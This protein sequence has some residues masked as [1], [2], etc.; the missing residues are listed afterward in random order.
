MSVASQHGNTLRMFRRLPEKDRVTRPTLRVPCLLPLPALFLLLRLREG[1]RLPVTATARVVTVNVSSDLLLALESPPLPPLVVV[2]MAVVVAVTALLEMDKKSA[3]AAFG[4][5]GS[6]QSNCVRVPLTIELAS[7]SPQF[8][9]RS[10]HR[11]VLNVP[12]S[13]AFGSWANGGA[14]RKAANRF[15]AAHELRPESS[16]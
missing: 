5:K 11:G 2:A 12:A 8:N 15:H 10:L 13:F 3:F 1:I 14:P 7:T 16:S 4:S 6:A 9:I